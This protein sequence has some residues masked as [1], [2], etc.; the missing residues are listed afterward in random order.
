[1]STNKRTV[2]PVLPNPDRASKLLRKVMFQFTP[3]RKAAA[4]IKCAAE[5][6]GRAYLPFKSRTRDDRLAAACMHSFI[7]IWRAFFIASKLIG[8]PLVDGNRYSTRNATTIPLLFTLRNRRRRNVSKPINCF[9][10]GTDTQ[11]TPFRRS[12]PPRPSRAALHLKP[13]VSFASVHLV[14]EYRKFASVPP[15][16]HGFPPVSHVRGGSAWILA[17]T[18]ASIGFLYFHRW[19]LFR[20]LRFFTESLCWLPSHR[21]TN[22]HD[23]VVSSVLSYRRNED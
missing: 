20:Q 4:R 3:S 14:T 9:T 18:S 2:Y 22:L 10:S 17:L 6:E 1:M 13:A 11:F 21:M 15:A 19:L 12:L 5:I 23:R 8:L 7:P 16:F